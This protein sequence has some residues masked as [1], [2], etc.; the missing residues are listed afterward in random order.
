[1]LCEPLG[2][3]T[4]TVLYLQWF[5]RT[6]GAPSKFF[7]G[8]STAGYFG[9]NAVANMSFDEIYADYKNSSATMLP[10]RQELVELVGDL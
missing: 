2:N 10:G 8:M 5:N 3:P 7:Y 4:T 9:G 6:Y 1:V